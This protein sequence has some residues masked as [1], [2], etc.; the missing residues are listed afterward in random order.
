MDASDSERTGGVRLHPPHPVTFGDHHPPQAG[1]GVNKYHPFSSA[2]TLPPFSASFT[3]TCL[4][5]QT[6]IDAE[7]LVLPV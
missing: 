5:S 2:G 3:I 6:F 1:E 7:S 4:C